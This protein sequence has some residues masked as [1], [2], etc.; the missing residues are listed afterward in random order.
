MPSYQPLQTQNIP[1]ITQIDVYQRLQ[2]LKTSK[3][4]PPNQLPKRLIK[5]FAVEI[6]LPLAHV[7]NN[8]IKFGVFPSIWKKATIVPLAKKIPITELGDIR[9]ISLTPDFGKTLEFFLSP[10]IMAD[11]KENIDADQ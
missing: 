1:S 7:F 10:W 3:A 9:P 8:C 2:L 11:I 4:S 5:E 6:S